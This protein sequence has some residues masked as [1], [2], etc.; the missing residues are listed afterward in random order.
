MLDCLKGFLHSLSL[1]VRSWLDLV[2]ILGLLL[3]CLGNSLSTIR[4]VKQHAHSFIGSLVLGSSMEMCSQLISPLLSLYR[5]RYSTHGWLRACC[6]P[7]LD[8]HTLQPFCQL[9]YY[10]ELF[11]KNWW[12]NQSVW[13]R[14]RG[15]GPQ[16]PKKHTVHTKSLVVLHLHQVE[17]GPGVL[18]SLESSTDICFHEQ[19]KELQLRCH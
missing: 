2:L 19:S 11:H 8:T 3:C 18:V 16:E 6:M 9:G 13:R 12:S 14:Q 17:K 7:R 5:W 4:L 1:Y 10:V 15:S